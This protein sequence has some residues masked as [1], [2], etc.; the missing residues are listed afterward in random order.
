[1]PHDER[2]FIIRQIRKIHYVIILTAL[3]MAAVRHVY[4]ECR[5]VARFTFDV[6]RA[7]VIVDNL[8]DNADP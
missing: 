7:S 8:I 1:M 3:T 4:D 6:D 5:S 2:S